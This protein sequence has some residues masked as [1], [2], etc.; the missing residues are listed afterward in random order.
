M[1]LSGNVVFMSYRASLT[2]ELAVKTEKPPFTNLE[3]FYHSEYRFVNYPH[4]YYSLLFN[5]SDDGT[6]YKKIYNSKLAKLDEKNRDI[7]QQE[8]IQ[9]Y[10][11]RGRQEVIFI[12]SEP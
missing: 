12:Q 4:H 5:D 2:S 11:N 10:L 7:D 9:R 6:I 1:S 3:E 8:H